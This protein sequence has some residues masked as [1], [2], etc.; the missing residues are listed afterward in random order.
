MQ[1]DS[2]NGVP[3]DDSRCL[4][5]KV[6][7]V[8]VYWPGAEQFG[9][10]LRDIH[11]SYS[12]NSLKRMRCKNIDTLLLGTAGILCVW[13]LQGCVSVGPCRDIWWLYTAGILCGW[14]V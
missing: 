9:N 2:K 1:A 4:T 5:I 3:N 10:G 12:L 11:G 14:A 7:L 8:E 6:A 13:A